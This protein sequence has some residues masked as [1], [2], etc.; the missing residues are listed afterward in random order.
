MNE[1]DGWVS[2]DGECLHPTLPIETLHPAPVPLPDELAATGATADPLV[3]V[4]MV[5][6]LAVSLGLGLLRWRADRRSVSHDDH[7]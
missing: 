1:C 6:G 4:A 2:P 3:T 7:S 5:A